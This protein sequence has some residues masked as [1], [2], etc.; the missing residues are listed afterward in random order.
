HL[1]KREIDGVEV[2]AGV[3]LQLDE[4]VVE[5]PALRVD[6]PAPAS[7][8][9]IA[10][11]CIA[12]DNGVVIEVDWLPDRAAVVAAHS[13]RPRPAPRLAGL[14]LGEVRVVWLGRPEVRHGPAQIDDVAI[15]P[16]AAAGLV[17]AREREGVQAA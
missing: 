15:D 8:V 17:A 4:D 16:R 5:D 2:Q 12:G 9:V 7:A 14:R 13:A 1:Q 11:G 10:E 6:M 3:A